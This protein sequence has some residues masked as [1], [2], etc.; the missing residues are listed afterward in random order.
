MK[1]KRYRLRANRT[2]HGERIMERRKKMSSKEWKRRNEAKK[3]RT[4]KRNSNQMGKKDVLC[5]VRRIE[6]WPKRTVAATTAAAA[7]AATAIDDRRANKR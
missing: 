2:T 5:G 3:N 1:E 4:L 7:A 6:S